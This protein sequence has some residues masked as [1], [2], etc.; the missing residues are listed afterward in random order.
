MAAHTYI[1]FLEEGP[2]GGYGVS[3]PD[4][5]GCVSSGDTLDDA[6][7]NAKEAL[8]LHLDGMLEDGDDLPAARSLQQIAQSGDLPQ[9]YFVYSAVTVDMDDKGERVNVYLPKS[10]LRQIERFG[11]RTGID[12]RSTFFKLAARHYIARNEPAN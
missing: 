11:E 1:A 12:N 10:L 2:D 3:F 9:A 8:A 6:A 5:P 4:L 7:A